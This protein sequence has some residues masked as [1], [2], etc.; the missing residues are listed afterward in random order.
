MLS[1]AACL[2]HATDI[3]S[4]KVSLC[5]KRCEREGCYHYS[6]MPYAFTL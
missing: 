4:Q 3:L 2:K 5:E 6:V 1:I